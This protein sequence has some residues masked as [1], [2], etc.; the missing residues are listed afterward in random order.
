MVEFRKEEVYCVPQF[1][2]AENP[3]AEDFFN[4]VVEIR[5]EVLK[6]MLMYRVDKRQCILTNDELESIIRFICTEK[7]VS[8]NFFCCLCLIFSYYFFYHCM[9]VCVLYH[10][11]DFNNNN[12]NNNKLCHLFVKITI[13]SIFIQ[14]M[15]RCREHKKLE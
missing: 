5:V 9:C 3:R 13:S 2:A 4:F 6:D 14:K 1:L 11:Y 8:I 15:N 7:V 10:E 12:N